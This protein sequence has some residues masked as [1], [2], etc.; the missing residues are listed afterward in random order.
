MKKKFTLRITI[1][2][3]LGILAL[4]YVSNLF[5]VD[6]V[7]SQETKQ[8]IKQDT[9]K[10]D[11]WVFTE[12]SQKYTLLVN[13]YAMHEVMWN[14]NKHSLY[15]IVSSKNGPYVFLK[16]L[17]STLLPPILEN[18][19]ENISFTTSHGYP[20]AQNMQ[21]KKLV[22]LTGKFFIY[23]KEKEKDNTRAIVIDIANDYN[24][25]TKAIMA[26]SGWAIYEATNIL[27]MKQAYE[28]L[29]LDSRLAAIR[30]E[31]VKRF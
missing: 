26:S 24:L 29:Q 21:N 27:N 19:W 22:M 17:S 11:V 3:F 16:P 7:N 6:K 25:K 2:E 1:Y 30:I 28:E 10:K 23:I 4:F 12:R 20:V 13:T 9:T 5:F 8:E 18:G 15:S 31:L 14:R